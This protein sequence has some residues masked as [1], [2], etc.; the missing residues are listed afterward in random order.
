M[1]ERA[2]DKFVYRQRIDNQRMVQRKHMHA[3]YAKFLRRS[4]A[5]VFDRVEKQQQFI[6]TYLLK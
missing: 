6:H 5:N 1:L 2:Q 4:F 3:I